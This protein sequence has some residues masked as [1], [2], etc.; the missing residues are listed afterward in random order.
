MEVEWSWQV[1]TPTSPKVLKQAFS[2]RIHRI[3]A[4]LPHSSKL[5]PRNPIRP[6]RISV[7]LSC[8]SYDE[9][10]RQAKWPSGPQ[11]LAT[12]PTSLHLATTIRMGALQVESPNCGVCSDFHRRGVFIGL[13]WS[14]TDLVEAVTNQVAAKPHGRPAVWISL[15]WLRLLLLV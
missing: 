1:G 10:S 13:C 4:E 14:S 3:P 2:I 5:E 11:S 7:E 15:H 6:W 8:S 12:L 9:G